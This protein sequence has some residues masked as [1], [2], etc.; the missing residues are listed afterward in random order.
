MGYNSFYTKFIKRFLD[1]LISLIAIVILS[2]VLI[3]VALLVR[4]KLGSPVIFKQARP[5]MNGKEFEMMKFRSMTNE[6]DEFG[7]LMPDEK[8]LTRFGRSL[9]KTSLDE[10][11]ELFNILRGDMSIVGPRPLLV[12]YLPYYTD[13]EQKRHLVRPGLTGLS[14]V[15][16]RNNL[17]W[18]RRL[19][20]DSFY[21]EHL[22]LWMDFK[23]ILKTIYK[24][25]DQSDIK[26]GNELQIRSLDVE[27]KNSNKRS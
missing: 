27:R 19:Y 26:S 2:P 10:L 24:I 7:Q 23:I 20:L 15:N 12:R 8:R 18:D 11:P 9:R 3:F 1:I 17:N 14:Q 25:F 16:G 4:I 13:T 5:G 6:K 21:V 22:S